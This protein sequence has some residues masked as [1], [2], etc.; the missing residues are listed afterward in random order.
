MLEVT[1]NEQTGVCTV[2]PSGKL[3]AEDFSR[4]AEIV[5]PYIE[6]HGQLKGLM[7]VAEKF[8]GWADFSALI[9]HMKFV[10]E[11]QKHI[12]RV[13][14]VSDSSILSIMPSM[15]DHFVKADVKHF[16]FEDLDQALIWLVQTGD[17]NDLGAVNT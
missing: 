8:P 4:A 5:D 11:H 10:G 12:S 2:T 7:I 6:Q 17:S 16:A 3:Q 13:A 15:L 1:L 9:A 14:A